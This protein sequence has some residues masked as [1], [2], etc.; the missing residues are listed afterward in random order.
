[1]F[2]TQN[3]YTFLDSG[4]R[5]LFPHY[6]KFPEAAG[7]WLPS[8]YPRDCTCSHDLSRDVDDW[9]GATSFSNGSSWQIRSGSDSP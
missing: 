7:S 9:L 5:Q 3:G 8:G 1:M 2:H 6:F 4:F